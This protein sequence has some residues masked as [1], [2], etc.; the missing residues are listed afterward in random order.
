MVFAVSEDV[1]SLSQFTSDATRLLDQLRDE[2]KTLVLTQ[3]GRARA[4]VSDLLTSAPTYGQG[5]GRR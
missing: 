5:V 1:L 3:N 2:P 4:V